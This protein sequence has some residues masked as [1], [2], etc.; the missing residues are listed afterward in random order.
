MYANGRQRVPWV[1]AREAVWPV[2]TT[3][4]Q[5]PRACPACLPATAGM[6]PCCTRSSGELEFAEFKEILHKATRGG[7]TRTEWRELGGEGPGAGAGAGPLWCQELSAGA[8]AG[9]AA[10]LDPVPMVGCRVW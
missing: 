1:L 2:S 3:G 8:S 6:R 5:V 10:V 7:G 4:L 9:E